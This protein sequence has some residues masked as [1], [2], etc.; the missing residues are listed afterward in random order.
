MYCRMQRYAEF[1]LDVKKRIGLD[2]SI[3]DTIRSYCD[4]KMILLALGLGISID[5]FLHST[6][7]SLPGL[8]AWL[9]RGCCL[10]W[11]AEWGKA[12]WRML[13][14]ARLQDHHDKQE[15]D[16]PPSKTIRQDGK[17]SKRWGW[18][19]KSCFFHAFSLYS[20]GPWSHSSKS[21]VSSRWLKVY[22]ICAEPRAMIRPEDVPN[23]CRGVIP[24][25]APRPRQSTIRWRWVPWW[26][27]QQNAKDV[28]G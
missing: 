9:C 27:L 8:Q 16:P 14:A 26:R 23:R 19:R 25:R 20:P 22:V 2:Q 13:C 4:F 21:V 24:I 1:I 5:W 7:L 3:K 6:W 12:L 18:D 17:W 11:Q 15:T 28:I 10:L